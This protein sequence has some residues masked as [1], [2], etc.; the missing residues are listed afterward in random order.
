MEIPL[1]QAGGCQ[2]G[3]VRYLLEAQPVTAYACHCTQ[4]QKQSGSAFGLSLIVPFAGLRITQGEVKV[5]RR[6]VNAE[7]FTDCGFCPDCGSRLYHRPMEGPVASLKPGTLDDRSWL[8]PVGHIFVDTA[9]DWTRPLRESD[10]LCEADRPTDFAA[11]A[12]AWAAL[13]SPQSN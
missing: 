8:Q 6:Q 9:Q 12:A 7:R 5:W 1:P 3:H 10:G 4:C 11:L 13:P 2:C